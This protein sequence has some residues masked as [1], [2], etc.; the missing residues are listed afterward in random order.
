MQLQPNRQL[1]LNPLRGAKDPLPGRLRDPL[2]DLPRDLLL[3]DARHPSS[4]GL[5]QLMG[6]LLRDQVPKKRQPRRSKPLLP[7]SRSWDRVVPPPNSQRKRQA[8]LP[9]N[10]QAKEPVAR[11]AT[12]RVGTGSLLTFNSSPR[13]R[14]TKLKSTDFTPPAQSVFQTSWRGT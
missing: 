1:L 11:V 4:M 2:P 8:V 10:H 14:R 13:F 3:E 7:D 6:D 12:R 5:G 9:P